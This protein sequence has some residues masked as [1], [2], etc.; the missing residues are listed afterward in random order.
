M[1]NIVL[2][3]QRWNEY[4]SPSLS[5]LVAIFPGEPGLA[6]F[7]RAKD[8]GSD[9]DHWSCKTCKAPVKSVQSS[10]QI[11]TTNKPTLSFL[12]AGCPS[13]RLTNSVKALKG[14]MAQT[15]SRSITAWRNVAADCSG[16]E[17]GISVEWNRSG[18]AHVQVV[19]CG[20]WSG[21]S[22][23]HHQRRTRTDN[24][25]LGVAPPWKVW[26]P[27]CTPNED[28]RAGY[29]GKKSCAYLCG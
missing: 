29:T 16:S 6:G 22:S 5:V 17:E 1:Q 19:R 14:I 26:H 24:F 27:S 23:E 25:R 4:I 2:K 21:P 13:C 28:Y 18:L 10:S 15:D 12:Q 9:G 7:I 3:Q 8:D 20:N 11:V